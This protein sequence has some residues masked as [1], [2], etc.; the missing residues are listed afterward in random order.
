MN[1]P[2][3]IQFLVDIKPYVNSIMLL[4]GA[5]VFPA[6]AVITVKGLVKLFPK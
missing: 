2:A 5:V 3:Q 6:I 4:I 1:D